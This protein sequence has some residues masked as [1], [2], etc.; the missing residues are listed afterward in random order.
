VIHPRFNAFFRFL[1]GLDFIYLN[2]HHGSWPPVNYHKEPPAYF[3]FFLWESIKLRVA[4][5]DQR[6]Y[7]H[8]SDTGRITTNEKETVGSWKTGPS[9]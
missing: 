3:I 7:D 1:R 8:K 6:D 9:T 2:N 4:M 5:M